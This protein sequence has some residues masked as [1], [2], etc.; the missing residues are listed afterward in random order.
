M[1]EVSLE[2]VCGEVLKAGAVKPGEPS[3]LERKF[4]EH[5]ARED[6]QDSP[7]QWAEAYKRIE[8]GREKAKSK[9]ARGAQG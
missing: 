9:S 1:A 5:L 4:R 6:H 7:A 3:E 8:A 2:C